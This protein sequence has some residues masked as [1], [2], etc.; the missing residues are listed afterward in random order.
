MLKNKVR[1]PDDCRKHT[2]IYSSKLNSNEIYPHYVASTNAHYLHSKGI[3]GKGLKVGILDTGHF[4]HNEFNGL[5]TVLVEN[6]TDSSNANDN[7]SHGTHV[8]GIMRMSKNGSGYVGML[9]DAEYYI[10]KVLSDIGE[11]EW[12]EK[13]IHLLVDQGVDI[14]NASL[15]G[16]FIHAGVERALKRAHEAGI[17]FVTAS[18]NFGSQEISYP[19]SSIYS[20][21]VGSTDGDK[22]IS[23]FSDRGDGLDI[24]AIGEN[25]ISTINSQDNFM[26]FNGTS[27]ASPVVCGVIGLY[28]E[29]LT[30]INGEKPDMNLLLKSVELGA[31][32]LGDM[33]YDTTYGIG[34]AHCDYAIELLNIW[35]EDKSKQPQVV[36]PISD[37]LRNLDIA[38]KAY[39]KSI[40]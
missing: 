10:V 38:L 4:N 5:K 24:V 37:E 35:E 13:G 29:V 36:E 40:Q 23:A 1:I 19:A 33:G 30:K 2:G 15:G 6:F 21:A 14:I 16:D 22:I 28:K 27:M 3:T 9:P 12:L 25:S 26:A 7:D 39:L 11:W 17:V 34:F 8:Q 32:D 20:I 31:K 18:G